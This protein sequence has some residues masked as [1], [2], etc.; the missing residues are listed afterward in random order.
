MLDEK[1]VLYLARND[2]D[3]SSGV[4]NKIG[5][6]ISTLRIMGYD[7]HSLQVD[8]DGKKEIATIAKKI[9]KT[10]AKFIVIR[11]MGTTNLFLQPFFF[12]ARLQGKTLIMDI[13]TPRKAAF[14][15]AMNTRKTKFSQLRYVVLYCINGPWTMWIMNNILLSGDESKWHLFGNNKRIIKVGNGIRMDRFMLRKCVALWPS[16]TLRVI[17]VANISFYNGFDRVI[18]AINFWNNK[19]NS[20]YRVEL[21]IAGEGPEKKK[22]IELVK[23]YRVEDSV[24]FVG[25]KSKDE[26]IDYYNTSHLALDSL[27]L[28][29]IALHGISTLKVLE[30]CL[31][32][33]PFISSGK[34]VNFPNPVPFRFEIEDNDSFEGIVEIFENFGKLRAGF[35]DQDIRDY[36][37]ANLSIESKLRKMGF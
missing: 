32:G 20:R 23:T 22:L 5:D 34:D 6:T 26:L 18:Q 16:S 13:P 10:K 11:S 3:K 19:E 1:K 12:I 30:Y 29:R 15:E 21:T 37:E 27:G 14:H 28:H 8:Y 25:F 35:T 24:K 9:V 31:V 7:A 17:G 4:N 33:I 36:A 2:K